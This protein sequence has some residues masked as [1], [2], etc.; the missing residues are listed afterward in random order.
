MKLIYTYI[1]ILLVTVGFSQTVIFSENFDSGTAPVGW[2]VTGSWEYGVAQTASTSG[3]DDPS[4]DHTAANTNNYVYGQN[5]GG[6]YGNNANEYLQTAAFDCSASTGISLSYWRY[7]NFEN[8]YDKSYVEISTDGSNWID[9]G[10]VIYPQDIEWTE[11]N[12]D[13]SAY[14]DGESTVYIRW[15]MTSDGSVVYSGWNIDDFEITANCASSPS[16]PVITAYPSVIEEGDD[17][18]LD[19]AYDAGTLHWYVNGCRADE[20]GTADQ[21]TETPINTL[22]YYAAVED[23]NGCFS[24]CARVQVIVAQ[25]CDISAYAD[26]QSD[27]INICSG[28]SVDISAIGECGFLMDDSFDDGSLSVGWSSNADPMFNNPCGTGVDGTTYIWIGSASSF[29]R[30][31]ITQEYSVTADCQICF[32]MKYAEQAGSGDCEGPDLTNEGVHI[33]WSTDDG[34]TWTDIDYFD[35]NGGHDPQY[36]NWNHYC[37]YVPAAAAGDFT[38]FR[39]FQDVTSGN[40]YDH[41]GLDNVEITCPTP[42]QT[43]QW[44]HGPTELDPVA[45]VSPT[46]TTSYTVILNDGYNSN[47]ADTA[48][49]VVNVLGTPNTSDEAACNSGD[50]VTLLATGGIT[51]AWYSASTGGTLLGTNSSYTLN[52]LTATTSVYV[53]ATYPFDSKNYT[54][55]N[56]MEGWIISTPCKSGNNWAYKSDGGNGVLF[57]SDPNRRRTQLIQSPVI[58]VQIVGI[59]DF[60]FE[61][62]FST[63]DG[64]DEGIVVYRLDGGAW[65]YA[66][67]TTNGYN[68]NTTIDRSMLNSCSNETRDSYSGTQ[69]TYITSSLE[70]DVSAADLLEVAFLFTSD[71]NTPG[72]GWYINSVN[73]DGSG[74]GSCNSRAEATAI[75]GDLHATSDITPPSCYGNSDGEITGTAADALGMPLGG[76]FTYS[77]STGENVATV[78]NVTAGTYNLTIEDQYNCTATSTVI[79]PDATTPTSISSVS[80]TSGDCNIDS[81][82]EW[83]YIVDATDDSKVIA[84]VFDET[85]GN[86]L[87]TTESETEISA[88]VQNYN[89]EHYL[90]R[91]T[92]V[93]PVS[94]GAAT[95]RIYFTQA[96]LD[97]LMA[98]DASITG[99]GDLAVTKC[100]DTG[101]WQNCMLVASSFSASDIG[102]GYYAQVSVTSFSKF[103]IH[104]DTKYTLPVELVSFTANCASSNVNLKWT[105]SVE[106]NNDYF[107]IYRSYDGISFEVIDYVEGNG[108]SNQIINYSYNDNAVNGENVFYKLEQFDYNGVSKESKIIAA[109]CNNSEI[110]ITK[111]SEQ[112]NINF[113]GK[114]NTDYSILLVNNIGQT[115]LSKKVDVS[116]NFYSE[117]INTSSLEKGI[118]YL[119]V[120]SS[121]DIITEKIL[122]K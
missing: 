50:N 30:E 64:Y 15:R 40:N 88:T 84:A 19:G 63:E 22:F 77:W 23:A 113:S 69:A 62:K 82:N 76:I 91:V 74:S 106:I 38:R 75:L 70:I 52:N 116:E 9:L 85:G 14:A 11:I 35:P 78:S 109:E 101:A 7:A 120:I 122:I 103:Y 72:D 31:L 46:T 108:N 111:Y 79:L 18:L 100:D 1:L 112:I 61:H 114:E 102:S 49:V 92:R 3:N 29:P 26:G 90:Q 54:F 93:T 41:W 110:L 96:E 60:S 24:E 25:P 5:L 6:A 89:G 34:A 95:V 21:L 117:Q 45:D 56:D 39:F 67:P 66:Q 115:I 118:Y 16:A 48:I 119:S 105:T 12:I 80:G 2:T 43:F 73:I 37:L 94:Q 28:T 87:F 27:T 71:G 10:E 81:P 57:A 4:T 36:I 104:K 121:D 47:N 32:D 86:S 65:I 83:V 98:A 55:D 68:N 8:N 51:Y 53:E 107:L 59:I 58:D 42:S 20:I 13:I 33:Q 44:S 97:A 17:V 99:I